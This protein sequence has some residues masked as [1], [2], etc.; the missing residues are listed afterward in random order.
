MV[1]KLG[2]LNTYQGLIIPL[3]TSATA[4]FFFHQFFRSVP[5]ELVEAARIDGVGPVKFF[6]D[7]LLSGLSA[8]DN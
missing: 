8:M 4:R 1:Q 3:I 7:I 2:M 6:L 5:E